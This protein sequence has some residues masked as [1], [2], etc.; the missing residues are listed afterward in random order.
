MVL[1]LLAVGLAGLLFSAVPMAAH[2]G[3]GQPALVGPA[4]MPASPR[5]MGPGGSLVAAPVRPLSGL[6]VTLTA[7]PS[8]V[9]LGSP[10]TFTG[11]FNPSTSAS[12]SLVWSWASLS[13]PCSGAAPMTATSGS[14]SFSCDPGSAGTY[15]IGVT[16]SNS[17][18]SGS[19]SFSLT[20]VAAL[21]VTLM[22]NPSSLSTGQTLSVGF[23]ING[24]VAPYMLTWNGLPSSCSGS[25][26][27]RESSS[28]TSSFT[29]N[30][31]QT[32]DSEVSLT[33]TD[34]LSSSPETQSSPSQ[35]LSVSSNGNNNNNNKGGNNG[36]GS[37]NISIPFLS[38][39]G[40]DL[41]LILIG[42]VV[43]FVLVV[44]TAVSTLVTAIVVARRLPPRSAA[45]ATK[46]VRTC[47]SCGR[48]VPADT[49]FCPE[50][51]ASSAP[52]KTP[53]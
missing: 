24:G 1:A 23:S 18:L 21:S 43:A 30:P 49:K 25:A 32:G 15:D 8:T 4:S 35:S 6:T 39:L 34:S 7:N 42:A 37:G 40:S 16:V 11:T 20:V 29:C 2:P 38:N 13:G 45:L 52:P 47:A 14:F 46:A 3:A 33:V 41:Y 26:P 36:N 17:T 53:A 50:C 27:S 51:G 19:D 9:V 48:S 31:D 22:L 5:A 12:Y 28:G 10:T 44:I